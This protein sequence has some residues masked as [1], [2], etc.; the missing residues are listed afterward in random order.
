MIEKSNA[1]VNQDTQFQKTLE[2][3]IDIVIN[4]RNITI[5]RP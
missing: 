3:Q 2:A 5:A 1:T 4:N